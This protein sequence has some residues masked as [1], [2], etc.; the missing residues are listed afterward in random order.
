MPPCTAIAQ[1]VGRG[2]A[3]AGDGSIFL[4]HLLSDLPLSFFAELLGVSCE[5]GEGK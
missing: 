4:Q 5:A 2:R 1:E 3:G